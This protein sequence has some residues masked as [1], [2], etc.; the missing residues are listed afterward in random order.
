MT[1]DKIDD[2]DDVV[3]RAL[4]ETAEQMQPSPDAWAQINERRPSRRVLHKPFFVPVTAAAAVIAV[5]AVA[6]VV[7]NL[8]G[9]DHAVSTQ[10]GTGV[11]QYVLGSVPDGYKTQAVQ[12]A[13]REQPRTTKDNNP[14]QQAPSAVCR[15]TVGHGADRVCADAIGIVARSYQTADTSGPEAVSIQIATGYGSAPWPDLLS[16]ASRPAP[17]DVIVRGKP[18]RY[19]LGGAEL[20]VTAKIEMLTWTERPGIQVAITRSGPVQ[21]ADAMVKL[22]EDLRAEPLSFDVAPRVVA[23]GELHHEPALEH[24]QRWYLS[25]G[26]W[27]DKGYCMTVSALPAQDSAASPDGVVCADQPPPEALTVP[28]GLSAF[29]TSSNVITGTARTDVARVRVEREGAPTIELD[30]LGR[31]EGLGLGFWAVQVP[32]TAA[33]RVIPLD[34][35]GNPIDGGMS[36]ATS[37]GTPV[38][39]PTVPVPV[40]TPS[41]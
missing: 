19:A 34:A 6:L 41:P 15:Q 18:G 28:D 21:G 8:G 38:V 27:H 23:S 2:V 26:R 20:G 33:Y 14:E 9:K 4:H 39:T 37:Q 7:Q 22:A 24:P 13:F 17:V 3:R 12:P 40:P 35:S 5:V 16:D 31:D 25:I 29:D 36:F 32:T 1:P 30:V 10:P 11:Q